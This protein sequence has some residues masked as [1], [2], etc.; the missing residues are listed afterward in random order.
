MPLDIVEEL[1]RVGQDERVML[2]WR[3]LVQ[4]AASEI[5][6]LRSALRAAQQPPSQSLDGFA[7][8]LLSK[9]GVEELPK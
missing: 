5:E 7:T 9:L 2:I 6:D 4:R 3:D 1:R 8:A